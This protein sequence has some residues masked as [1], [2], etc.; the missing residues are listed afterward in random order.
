M[1][2]DTRKRSR[3]KTILYQKISHKKSWW[4]I[5]L[6]IIIFWL[7]I[8]IIRPLNCTCHNYKFCW[9][10]D[11]QCSFFSPRVSLGKKDL[12]VNWKRKVFFKKPSWWHRPWESVTLILLPRTYTY[13]CW[14]QFCKH[15]NSDN[16]TLCGNKYILM[17]GFRKL[18]KKSV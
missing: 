9:P 14:C 4:R 1:F 18:R 3:R 5:L 12:L 8:L 15:T 6:K 17:D 10:G 13:T 2:L 16:G 7:K 11:S